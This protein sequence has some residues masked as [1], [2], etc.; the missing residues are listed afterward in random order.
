M[1]KLH[2]SIYEEAHKRKS[3]IDKTKFVRGFVIGA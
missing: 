3:K 1:S 2:R